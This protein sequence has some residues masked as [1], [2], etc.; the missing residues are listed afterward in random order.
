MGRKSL[1]ASVAVFAAS[2]PFTG[3][4][5]HDGTGNATVVR[6]PNDDRTLIFT[7]FDT[8][9]LDCTPFTV[10]IAVAPLG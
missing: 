10:R 4:D 8:V 1:L 7:E 9:V 3:V 2:G 6:A 5:G